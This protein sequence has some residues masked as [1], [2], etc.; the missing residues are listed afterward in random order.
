MSVAGSWQGLGSTMPLPALGS[1]RLP[2]L[3]LLDAPP[4]PPPPASM[5]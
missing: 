2:A 3:P 5:E 1:D 4:E